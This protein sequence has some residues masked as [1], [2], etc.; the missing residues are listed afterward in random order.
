[1][2]RALLFLVIVVLLSLA[3]LV[4]FSP[5]ARLKRRLKKTHGRV[6]PKVNRRMVRFSVR[7]PKE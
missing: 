1:M 2:T 3:G 5:T 7:P 6:V 4:V